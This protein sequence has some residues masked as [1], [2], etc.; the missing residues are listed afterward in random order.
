MRVPGPSHGLR[1]GASPEILRPERYHLTLGRTRPSTPS[2]YGI[3]LTVLVSNSFYRVRPRGV[4]P[5]VG[6]SRRALLCMQETRGLIHL[7][8]LQE[9]EYEHRRP[10]RYQG[11]PSPPT[12]HREPHVIDRVSRRLR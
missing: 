2:L 7:K 6:K 11:S 3:P 10:G 12:R 1:H 9:K 8:S 5:Y 4:E